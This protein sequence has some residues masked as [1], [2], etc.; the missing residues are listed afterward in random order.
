MRIVVTAALLAFGVFAQAEESYLGLYMQ[1]T[2]IGYTSYTSAPAILNGANVVRSESLMVMDAA[3]LGSDL[4]LNFDTITV[5]KPDGTPITMKFVMTSGGRTQVIEAKFEGKKANL[6]INNTGTVTRQ[7]LAIPQ[8]APVIDDAMGLLGGEGMTAGTKRPFYILDPTTVSFIKNTAT[9]GGQVKVKV[10]GKEYT[11]T[12][13]T[14]SDPRAD[15]TFYLSAKG[16]LIKAEGPM[17]IEMLPEEKAVATKITKGKIPDLAIATSLKTDKPIENP[18][19]LKTL[20]LRVTGKDLSRI[21]SDG[22][23]T[24][25]GSGK[26]W[27]IDVHPAAVGT[28]AV[29]S[30]LGAA[31]T[32]AAWTKPSL[33]MPSE[34]PEFKRLAATIVGNNKTVSSRAFAIHDWVYKNMVPN[35][36][37]GVLR[38]ATEVLKSKEGV[39]RDYAILTGTLMRSAGIPTRLV[40]GLVNWDGTFYYHAW[41]EIWDGKQ[42]FAIDSTTPDKQVSAAHV[43]LSDGNVEQAFNYTFLEGAKLELLGAKPR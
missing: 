36:G 40:A 5:A 8:D 3:M 10:R 20:S 4:K 38:D 43:K 33:H 7:T 14:I 19:G 11:G 21:P 41:V 25:K 28:I 32:A 26:T 34:S 23:Q 2:K 39:C 35:A 24:V 27:T 18:G 42:W 1:G 37:I 17:G 16:D 31:K 12:Q 13:V 30:P 29:I 22:Y 6:L 15:T 9:V